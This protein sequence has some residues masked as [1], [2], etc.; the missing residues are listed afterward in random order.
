[1]QKKQQL[2]V[3]RGEEHKARRGVK[4]KGMME[5]DEMKPEE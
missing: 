5:G 1:M 2:A 4:T 3:K